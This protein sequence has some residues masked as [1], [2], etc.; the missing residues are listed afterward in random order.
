MKIKQA[1]LLL[2]QNLRNEEISDLLHVNVLCN[3]GNGTNRNPA[4]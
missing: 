3:S 1:L 4:T 2:S